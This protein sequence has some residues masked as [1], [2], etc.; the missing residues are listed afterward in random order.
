MT[1]C[2]GK[3]A[4]FKTDPITNLTMEWTYN[5]C[6]GENGMTKYVYVQTLMILPYGFKEF[7]QNWKLKSYSV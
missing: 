3:S 5:L 6:M 4:Y 2:G 7:D 1:W